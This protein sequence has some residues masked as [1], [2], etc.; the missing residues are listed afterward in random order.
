MDEWRTVRGRRTQDFGNT[1]GCTWAIRERIC[2]HMRVHPPGSAIPDDAKGCAIAL[3]NFDGVHL[4]HQAV[5]S[6]AR[7]HGARL[8]VA[9][10]RPHPRRFFQPAAPPFRLQTAAQRARAL[11]ALG[12][13]EVFEIGFDA[14]LARSTDEAF[15]QTVL[16][17]ALGARHVSVGAD[18]RFG[19]GRMGDVA[20]LKALGARF[21]FGVGAVAPVGEAGARY[22]ST[23]IRT[24]IE[25]GDMAGAAAQLSRP[26]AVEGEVERG[27]QR[28][29]GFGFATANVALG[30][31]VRPRLG[32]YAVR[33]RLGDVWRDGVASV[34]VNPT[35]GA[36]AAPVL[37]AHL[38]DFD[39]DL[40]GQ[41]IEVALIAFL[42]DEA[43]FAD[44]DALK[45]QMA[46]DVEN[47]QAALR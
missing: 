11:K 46:R 35:V 10:F 22:S 2:E 17:D 33:V 43:H 25:A 27:F 38:F 8:G 28:G 37:E 39:A 15:A 41:T 14:A 16:R 20:A 30:E 40:Y 26:W 23:A 13:E 34:G 47:A 3:G 29:R 32:I 44:V 19:R 31:Y 1:S 4:G 18:F 7:A 36:L 6:D 9:T 5:L 24:A 45:A 21:G 42:R 12:V